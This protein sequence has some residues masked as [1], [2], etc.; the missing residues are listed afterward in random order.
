[1]EI[2]KHLQRHLNELSFRFNNQK[3]P[4]QWDAGAA[5]GTGREFALCESKRRERVHAIREA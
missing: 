5:A 4:N 2:K 3:T 1:L